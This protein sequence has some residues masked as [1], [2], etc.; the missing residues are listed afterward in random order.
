MTTR[1]GGELRTEE[2]VSLFKREEDPRVSTEGSAVAIGI[3]AAVVANHH[4]VV[5]RQGPG[6]SDEVIDDFTAEPT[7]GGLDG[8]TKRLASGPVPWRWQKPTSMTWLPLNVA[9]CQSG[10]D[11]ALVGNRHSARLRSALAGKNKSDPIDADVVSRA[12]VLFELRPARVPTADE[13]ALRRAVQRRG[14]V[15]VDANRCLRRVIS[16][17]PSTSPASSSKE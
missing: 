2:P 12:E 6:R 11:L 13:L 1:S 9:L 5:R 10:V 4:I 15:L 3:D 17:T 16:L 7:L 14:K 8:L